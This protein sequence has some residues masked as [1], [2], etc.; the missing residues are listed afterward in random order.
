[1]TGKRWA[2][3]GRDRRLPGGAG[4]ERGAGAEDTQGE[5]APAGMMGRA[6]QCSLEEAIDVRR[7]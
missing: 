1:M 6:G 5:M 3:T 2:E 7:R 4:K